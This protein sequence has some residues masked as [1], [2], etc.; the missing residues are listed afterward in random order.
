[1]LKIVTQI[2][3]ICQQTSKSPLFKSPGRSPCSPSWL[4]QCKCLHG[5]F[6]ILDSSVEIDKIQVYQISNFLL[7]F[8]SII[9]IDSTG[10]VVESR[11]ISKNNRRTTC[12]SDSPALVRIEELRRGIGAYA[13]CTPSFSAIS[14]YSSCSSFSSSVP[15]GVREGEGGVA[16]DEIVRVWKTTT[17]HEPEYNGV[18]VTSVTE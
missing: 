17:E 15:W 13:I 6:G 8:Y 7:V 14:S 10:V 11:R 4:R 12:V 2:I 5:M 9:M 16:G 1:M 18:G 3:T